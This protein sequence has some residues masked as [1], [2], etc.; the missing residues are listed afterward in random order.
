MAIQNVKNSFFFKHYLP[1]FGALFRK[2]SK[3]NILIGMLF[4]VLFA[5]RLHKERIGRHATLGLAILARF[6]LDA[7]ASSVAHFFRIHLKNVDEKELVNRLQLILRYQ[8]SKL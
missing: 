8:C 7:S 6:C 2:L 3:V 4:A 1:T 5:T